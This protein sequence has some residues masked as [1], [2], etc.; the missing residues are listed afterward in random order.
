MLMQDIYTTFYPLFEQSLA[1]YIH[2]FMQ[3]MFK[4]FEQ[5]EQ[6]K[7]S[8]FDSSYRKQWG[9]LSD[10]ILHPP[11][12]PTKN[13]DAVYVT[14]L[15]IDNFTMRQRKEWKARIDEDLREFAIELSALFVTDDSQFKT[16]KLKGY[17]PTTDIDEGPAWLREIA[18]TIF[19]QMDHY[20]T[21][22]R[23]RWKEIPYDISAKLH[24]LFSL[25]DE[26]FSGETKKAMD[27]LK[28]DLENTSPFHWSSGKLELVKE[29]G[30]KWFS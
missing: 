18:Y 20:E 11:P 5:A 15:V 16:S 6:L 25:I 3:Q 9:E 12:K 30:D 8:W 10:R 1:V 17:P 7:T 27:K 21:M 13:P 28:R 14:Q 24:N 22:A 29:N 23:N 26:Q 4:T 2:V 19:L